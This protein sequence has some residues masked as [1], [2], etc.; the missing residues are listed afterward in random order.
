MSTSAEA[1]CLHLLDICHAYPHDPAAPGALARLEA[2]RRRGVEARKQAELKAAEARARNG[3]RQVAVKLASA[4]R[5]L[6][7]LIGTRAGLVWDSKRAW[8][9]PRIRDKG[10]RGAGVSVRPEQPT[11]QRP[12]RS[13][14]SSYRWK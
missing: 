2:Y 4:R 6:I 1:C 12:P 8:L 13:R 11:V 10:A 14:A 7:K 5:K 9:G 3:E